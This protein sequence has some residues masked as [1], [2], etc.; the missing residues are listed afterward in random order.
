MALPVMRYPVR[1]ES[2]I[3]CRI[4]DVKLVPNLSYRCLADSQF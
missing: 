1:N 4:E 2:S 3:R